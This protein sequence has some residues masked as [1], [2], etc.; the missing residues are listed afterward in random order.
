MYTTVT[1][2]DESTITVHAKGTLQAARQGVPSA[3][4]FT[5][6]IIH[7][8]GRF[9]GIKG[10]MTSSAKV[11]PPEKGEPAGKALG[12]QSLVYALPGK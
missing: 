2:H 12:E 8:T 10:T 7:G 4:K 6:D 5:G 11:L 1:F 3:I 9:Q